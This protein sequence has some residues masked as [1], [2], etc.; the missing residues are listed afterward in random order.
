LLQSGAVFADTR[1]DLFVGDLV[2][3][4]ATLRRES[5]FARDGR[6]SF[7][8][9]PLIPSSLVAV[10]LLL[11][12]L[13]F[14]SQADGQ[15]VQFYRV[16][17]IATKHANEPTRRYFSGLQTEFDRLQAAAGTNAILLFSPAKVVNAFAS[18]NG[19][20][21]IVVVYGGLLSFLGSDTDAIGAVLAHELGHVK[22]H[23]VAQKQGTD[24]TIS[25]LTSLAGLAF[26]V[27][28]AKKGK[29]QLVGI[30]T[31][32]AAVGHT[33]LIK[34]YTRDQ[35]READ[36]V[37][38]AFLAASGIDPEAA[39]RLQRKFLASPG[40]S[41]TLDILSTHPSTAERIDNLQ[42]AAAA[43]RSRYEDQLKARA[44]VEQ[45]REAEAQARLV[46]DERKAK[47]QADQRA[48]LHNETS[49]GLERKNQITRAEESF[50]F[51][52]RPP[53]SK[54]AS[55]PASSPPTLQC[56]D[57]SATR[58]TCL[59]TDATGHTVI[60]KCERREDQWQCKSL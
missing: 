5:H 6:F 18:V 53:S 42:V 33:L 48:T 59:E 29:P 36:H 50:A 45:N 34:A 24:A 16:G 56:Q 7:A 39:V 19:N 52:G 2:H 15:N 3:F 30:G 1:T 47:E 57:Q 25:I 4:S 10:A 51:G 27:Y 17:D 9:S 38:V 13:G 28:E 12:A 60:K 32:S 21:D 35:E 41:S 37:S 20:Q 11:F 54:P 46:A 14:T 22:Y 43:V 26:D 8:L 58:R 44:V 40:G 49:T 55:S 23:H 31:R